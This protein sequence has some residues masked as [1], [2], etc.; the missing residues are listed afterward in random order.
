MEQKLRNLYNA[1]L[2][3]ET[4]GMSTVQMAECIRYT[5]RLIAEANAEE[6]KKLQAKSKVT[7]E[8]AVEK[9]EEIVE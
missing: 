7:A 6:Q 3:I 2:K 9:Y 1:M 4:K 8:N 5:E